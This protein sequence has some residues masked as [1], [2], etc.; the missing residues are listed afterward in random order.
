M[1]QLNRGYEEGSELSKEIRS[2]RMDVERS[3][4]FEVG[5]YPLMEQFRTPSTGINKYY[6]FE[7]KP[8]PAVYLSELVHLSQL[9]LCIY[10]V[11][12]DTHFGNVKVLRTMT[13]GNGGIAYNITFEASLSDKNPEILQTNICTSI[14]LPNTKIKVMFVRIKPN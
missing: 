13:Y 6:D 9:A 2:F 10:N 12:E 8:I 11:K 7:N 3:G 1:R 5:Y 14:G 4:G